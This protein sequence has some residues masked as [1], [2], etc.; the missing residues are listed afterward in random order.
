MS[1]SFLGLVRAL[2][3]FAPPLLE[4]GDDL[5]PV[6]LCE[7]G[8]GGLARHGQLEQTPLVVGHLQLLTLPEDGLTPGVGEG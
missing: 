6:G 2:R 4:L 7:L 8:Q 1:G 3:G 5:V